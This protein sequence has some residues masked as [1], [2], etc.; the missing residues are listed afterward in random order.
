M[1]NWSEAEIDLLFSDL[2]QQAI[3]EKLGRS[4]KAVYSKANRLRV[5]GYDVPTKR[6]HGVGICNCKHHNRPVKHG[7]SWAYAKGCRCGFCK[8][9]RREASRKSSGSPR[10][11]ERN[12]AWHE[13]NREY[14]NQMRRVAYHKNKNNMPADEYRSLTSEQRIALGYKPLSRKCEPNCKCNRHVKSGNW[15]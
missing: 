10:V 3:A 7:T 14:A 5:D 9:A 15:K 12:R 2:S 4:I 13:R 1:N 6:I 8:E 11:R